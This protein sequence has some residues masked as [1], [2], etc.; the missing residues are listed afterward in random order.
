MYVG[1]VDF[2]HKPK[3]IKP[4]NFEN[5]DRSSDRMCSCRPRKFLRECPRCLNT[6]TKCGTI[7]K[8]IISINYSPNTPQLI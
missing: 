5:C 1:K 4:T 6:C 2:V 8:D 7:R 3:I